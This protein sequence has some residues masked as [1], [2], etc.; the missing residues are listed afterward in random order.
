MIKTT[1]PLLYIEGSQNIT[2][3]QKKQLVDAFF[4][5][6]RVANGWLSSESYSHELEPV[7]QVESVDWDNLTVDITSNQLTTDEYLKDTVVA[8]IFFGKLTDK[9]RPDEFLGFYFDSKSRNDG[10]YWDDND[11]RIRVKS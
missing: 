7:F 11:Q 10:A 8:M 9:L 3:D 4:A 6:H 1:L 5:E 2:K